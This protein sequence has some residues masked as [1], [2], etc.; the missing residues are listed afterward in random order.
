[1]NQLA[2]AWLFSLAILA[3]WD[4]GRRL[5]QAYSNRAIAARV[6]ALESVDHAST[7]LRI[8]DLEHTVTT[9]KNQIETMR[10]RPGSRWGA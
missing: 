9:L 4:V 3:I 10:A 7:G 2:L 5:S 8:A 6:A 1:M